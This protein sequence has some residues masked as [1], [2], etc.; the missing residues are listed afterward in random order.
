MTQKNSILVACSVFFFGFS[1]ASTAQTNA[2]APVKDAAQTPPPVG[3]CAS[4][5][6][7]IFT[8]VKYLQDDPER[9]PG[10]AAVCISRDGLEKP[11]QDTPR[12]AIKF[13]QVLDAR[14]LYVIWDSLPNVADYV[15]ASGQHIYTLFPDSLPQ[16]NYRL[17]DGRWLL[18]PESRDKINTLYGQ[19]FPLNLEDFVANLPDTF[20]KRILRVQIWQYAGILL[21]L[22]TGLALRYL[23]ILLFRRVG[24]RAIQRF[25]E[26]G[27]LHTAVMRADRPIGLL[28]F[29]A[30]I[31][32][33]FPQLLLPAAITTAVAVGMRVVSAS[34]LVWL[35]FRF[36]DALCDFFAMKAERTDSK[37]DDQLVPLARKSLKA[38]LTIIG[39]IFILQNL[40][41]DVD[42]LLAGLGIGGLA[43]ALAAKDT[44][45]NLFGSV[46]IFLDKPFQIGDFIKIGSHVEG[47]VE[48]VGFRSTRVRTGYN[49]LVSFP[50]SIVTN[51]TV[52][53]LGERRYRRYK[54]TLGLTYD[55]SPEQV[56][57]F[58]EGVRAVIDS[59][60]GMRKDFYMV[61]FQEFGPH[62]LD[63]MVYCFMDVPD[64]T[65][66]LRVRT[67]LNLAIMRL[68]RELGVGFAFPTQTLHV[69]QEAETDASSATTAELAAII[70]EF[71]TGGTFFLPNGIE[72][73]P[74]YDPKPPEENNET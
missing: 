27:W 42:S 47:T 4:P 44:A 53:N 18:T 68:A 70:S 63:V 60:P 23:A 29:A 69:R 3:E 52:D 37:L 56:Q 9:D 65:T 22:L 12:L 5:H 28:A 67:N 46:M 64:W 34:S 17:E 16:M 71:S 7:A 35:G 15:N 59:Q 49:S 26:P 66:E 10:H 58:C 19:T 32:G 13:K 51:S 55:T 54:T 21:V 11:A 38:F 45:A 1:A 61:E 62:S 14:G 8:L 50:N 57:A 6:N 25:T 72:I 2:T 73:S 39:G 31:S 24:L 40:N 43:V 74:G 41:V 48:E 33:L 36:A 30:V 20:Q